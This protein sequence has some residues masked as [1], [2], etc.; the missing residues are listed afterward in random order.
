[1]EKNNRKSCVDF[2]NESFL[3]FEDR[4]AKLANFFFMYSL[5]EAHTFRLV[6]VTYSFFLK[7]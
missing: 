1:M 2:G 7:K 5:D 3:R 4:W 6:T